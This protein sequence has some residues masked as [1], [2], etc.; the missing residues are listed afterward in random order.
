MYWIQTLKLG[1]I[2]SPESDILS[3]RW[4]LDNACYRLRDKHPIEDS[5]SC[6]KKPSNSLYAYW[7]HL[8]LVQSPSRE[9]WEQRYSRRSTVPPLPPGKCHQVQAGWWQSQEH[10]SPWLRT[11]FA[12]CCPRAVGPTWP[13]GLRELISNSIH[14]VKILHLREMTWQ[15]ISA[16]H[17]GFHMADPRAAILLRT[18]RS[19][20]VA[21]AS[22]EFSKESSAS[23]FRRL[24][25][26]NLTLFWN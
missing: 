20:S 5:Y 3:K 21:T 15:N 13:S 8:N 2:H 16:W 25:G 22:T 19:S 14:L 24:G 1:D 26:N 6:M 17:S 7:P 10:G 11:F 23:R 4:T 9:A 12:R 18:G